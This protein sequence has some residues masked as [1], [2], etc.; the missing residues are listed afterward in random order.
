[1]IVIILLTTHSHAYNDTHAHTHTHKRSSLL[2]AEK[3]SEVDELRPTNDVVRKSHGDC[4]GV[5]ER[6]QIPCDNGVFELCRCAGVQKMTR[7]HTQIEL[8]QGTELRRRR[9]RGGAGIRV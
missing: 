5:R 6:R 2:D 1:M 4:D 3:A 9:A 7:T 8:H